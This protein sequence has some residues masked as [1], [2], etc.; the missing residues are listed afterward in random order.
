MKNRIDAINQKV[1]KALEQVAEEEN[2]EFSFKGSRYSDTCYD[3]TLTVTSLS[4][5][6][7]QLQ[8]K[9]DE[10]FSRLLGFSENIVGKT[11]ENGRSVFTITKLN[12]NRPKYPISASNQNGTSYKFP[13]DSVKRALSL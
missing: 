8:E 4:K 10:D 3:S 13:V 12:L 6:A 2:V 7:K 1:L 9:E 5:D 11:F